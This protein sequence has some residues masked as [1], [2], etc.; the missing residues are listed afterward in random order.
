MRAGSGDSD[1]WSPALQ[2]EFADVARRERAERA[3]IDIE[4]GVAAEML[5]DRDRARPAL[6]VALDL[7]MLGPHADGGGAA[8]APRLRR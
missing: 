2:I 6:P 1:T 3:G 7:E 5:G 8:L 4:E